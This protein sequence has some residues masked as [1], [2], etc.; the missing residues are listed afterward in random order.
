MKRPDV[1]HL[2]HL[3]RLELDPAREEALSRDMERLLAFFQALE[4]LD[5]RGV[6]PGPYPFPGGLRP[7]EDKVEPGLPPE[8]VLGNA[9]EVEEG[10]FQ[11]PPVLGR[12]RGR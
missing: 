9:P 12:E 6:E 8:K 3:A 1:R 11:V 7:R 2:A 4:G 10:F 5:T